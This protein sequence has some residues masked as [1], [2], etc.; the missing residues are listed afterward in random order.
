M[1]HRSWGFR[2]ADIVEAINNVLDYTD[3]MGYENFISDRKTIDAVIRNFIVIGEASSRLP[4]ALV[5]K[6]PDVPWR[7]MRDM[8]NI[9]VHE[10]FGIDNRV[11][12]E[13]IKKNLPPI[14]PLLQK[15]ME[16]TA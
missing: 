14:L 15:I 4:D 5:E 8:R 13:T 7:E 3:G 1:P 10:Y 11:V 12:W 2:I 16:K 9:L 6:Y